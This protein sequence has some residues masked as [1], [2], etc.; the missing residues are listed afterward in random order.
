MD[1]HSKR[2]GNILS[3]EIPLHQFE[4]TRLQ[5]SRYIIALY[6][7]N[8]IPAHTKCSI[9]IEVV[10]KC[11]S[12]CVQPNIDGKLFER[13]F[14]DFLFK[15]PKSTLKN[16]LENNGFEIVELTETSWEISKK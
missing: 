7:F 10:N 11:I 5:V 15:D 12:F 13:I 2:D 1:I 6:E 4:S 3:I 8:F 14:H 9:N 16:D